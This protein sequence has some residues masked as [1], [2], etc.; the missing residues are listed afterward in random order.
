MVAV[1]FF[2]VLMTFFRGLRFACAATLYNTLSSHF[3]GG[4]L[5]DFQTSYNIFIGETRSLVAHQRV[6][7]L[8]L[9]LRPL[10]E[11]YGSRIR[12]KSGPVERH[13]HPGDL[14]DFI[15]TSG[16]IEATGILRWYPAIH[17]RFTISCKHILF[18]AQRFLLSYGPAGTRPRTRDEGG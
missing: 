7:L 14:L 17:S 12:G 9:S 1:G 8:L 2:L 4:N 10:S 16:N 6:S 13:R 5:V 15:T 18:C 11:A 3:A